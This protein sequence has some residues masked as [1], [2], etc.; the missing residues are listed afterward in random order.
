M[1][2]GGIPMPKI[3]AT[4]Y[5]VCVKAGALTRIDIAEH[6]SDGSFEVLSHDIFSNNNFMDTV[7]DILDAVDEVRDRLNLLH[8]GA[9]FT[10][11]IRRDDWDTESVRVSAA[12]EYALTHVY[13]RLVQ[14]IILLN[15]EDTEVEGVPQALIDIC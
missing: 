5:Y 2:K 12:L 13:D 10:Y 7:E 15:P 4:K 14:E 1:G 3:D 11:L 6:C 8:D 9:R